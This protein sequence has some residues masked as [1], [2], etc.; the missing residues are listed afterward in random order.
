MT[1]EWMIPEFVL[2]QRSGDLFSRPAATRLPSHSQAG[3]FRPGRHIGFQPQPA[4]CQRYGGAHAET[5]TA[6][7]S[8]MLRNRCGSNELNR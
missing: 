6:T 4:T 8:E 2:N 7:R 3:V 1:A 5:T